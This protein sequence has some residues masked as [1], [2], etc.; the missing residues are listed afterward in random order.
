VPHP[1]R[2]GLTLSNVFQ[3]LVVPNYNG[4]GPSLDVSGMGAEKTFTITGPFSGRIVVECSGDGVNFAPTQTFVDS[5]E[6]QPLVTEMTIACFFLRIRRL[7]ILAPAGSPVVQVAAV[8]ATGMSVNL[9]IPAANG[10]TPGA[11]VDVSGFGQTKTVIV[12]GDFVG[13]LV[14]TAS[15]DTG[16]FNAVQVVKVQGGDFFTFDAIYEQMRVEFLLLSSGSVGA[17]SV[18]AVDDVGGGAQGAQG[19]QGAAG[20][21]GTQGA[22]GSEGSQGAQ[23]PGGGAQGAQ[24][25]QGA[26]G[27]GS[28]GAQGDNGA[29]GSTGAQGAQ[30]PGGGAQGAQGANGT[31]GAQGATGAGAQGA[32]GATGSQGSQGG[33]GSQGAQG[34][35]GA[36]GTQGPGGTQ[37]A[38]GAQ[39]S[40]GAGLIMSYNWSVLTTL[41]TGFESGGNITSIV[42]PGNS[43]NIPVATGLYGGAGVNVANYVSSTS[44]VYGLVPFYA[45]DPGSAGSPGI[46]DSFVIEIVSATPLSFSSNMSYN[47]ELW[48][49]TD[50]T[51]AGAF[52]MI[53]QQA[54]TISSASPVFN[55]QFT[56][57]TGGATIASGVL[58]FF[59][60]YRTDSGGSSLTSMMVTASARII[61]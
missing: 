11:T 2:W 17:V 3:N 34:A 25:S 37:G 21:N 46:F 31:Q 27:T 60:L 50:P 15:A 20:T 47:F 56:P 30:G 52:T 58:L 44:K 24:G 23:G 5:P 18:C 61:V 49:T 9:P 22:Q 57:S 51:N 1:V 4:T 13:S 32:Q 59:V 54:F 38:Q 41:D 10:Y 6:G 39:G 40:A 7:E 43:G 26:T 28:Q 8:A 48:K 33:S 55:T 45:F 14:V 36:G 35:Q 53:A 42:A 16:A 12:C 29:Q 19:A